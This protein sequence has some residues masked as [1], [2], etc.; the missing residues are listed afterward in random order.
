MDSSVFSFVLWREGGGCVPVS[1]REVKCTSLVCTWLVIKRCTRCQS[2]SLDL[3][4]TSNSHGANSKVQ[5]GTLS[6]SLDDSLITQ[7]LLGLSPRSTGEEIVHAESVG[8]KEVFCA[9]S[10]K[11]YT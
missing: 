9:A 4:K 5:G 1:G 8:G 2:C 3:A 11:Q 6:V 7:H 10:G